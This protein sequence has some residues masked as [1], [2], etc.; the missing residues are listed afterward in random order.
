MIWKST[1]FKIRKR[2]FCME[3]VLIG[4]AV[5]AMLAGAIFFNKLR[6]KMAGVIGIGGS[7]FILLG[8][9][10]AV[11]LIGQAFSGFSG[12]NGVEIVMTLIFGIVGIGYMVFVMLTR[13]DSIASRIFLPFAAVLIGLGFCWRLLAAIFL[14]IPMDSGKTEIAKLPTEIYDTNGDSWYWRSGENGGYATYQSRK[15]GETVGFHTST[16]GWLP[17]GW[18][19]GN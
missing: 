5:V 14:K 4:L 10:C 6:R 3:G 8:I 13:C 7:Y 18:R 12:I 19:M 1:Q 11:M 9:M 16:D 17:H 2:R 15:T